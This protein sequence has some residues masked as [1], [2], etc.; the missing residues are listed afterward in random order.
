MR[1]VSV[2]YSEGDLFAVPL[3]GGGYGV[4]TVA[5]MNGD[6]A[7][8][9][10]FFGPRRDDVPS[11]EEVEGLTAEGAILVQTFGDLGLMS[12]SWPIV[13]RLPGWRREDWRMPAFGRRDALT[14]R[15]FR[16]EYA[17]DDP[18]SMPHEV[19]ISAQECEQLPEDGAAGS[20]FIEAR[21]SRLLAS[22]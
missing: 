5:R 8:T 18:N 13:G 12:G 15:C 9:G 21:L 19:E 6:G 20:G 10:Y 3:D 17:D 2:P 7:V 16:V 4:G 14:G 11:R 1:D 22:S